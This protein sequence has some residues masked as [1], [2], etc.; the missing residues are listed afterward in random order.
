MSTQETRER[1]RER[2]RER[3]FR[4]GRHKKNT[5]DKKMWQK[6]SIKL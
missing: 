2:E 3:A 4:V 5:I 1:E 6:D